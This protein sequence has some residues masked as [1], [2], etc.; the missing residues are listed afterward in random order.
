MKKT[1]GLFL[2]FAPEHSKSHGISRLLSFILTGIQK[3]QDT[4]IVI[5]TTEWFKHDTMAFLQNQRIDTHHIELLTTNK[6]ALLSRIIPIFL[7]KKSTALISMPQKKS[8]SAIKRHL[9]NFLM[10]H[11]LIQPVR[12]PLAEKWRRLHKKISTM[13]ILPD[14]LRIARLYHLFARAIY[15]A[16]RHRELNK[17]I[18]LINAR[19]DISIWFVPTLFWPEIKNIQAKKIIAVP[20]I[21]AVDFPEFFS[22]PSALKTVQ[23]MTESVKSGDH[24]ICYS[25]HVKQKHLAEA[26]SIEPD[27]ISVIPH[28]PVELSMSRIDAIQILH[29]YQ[30]T[31]LNNDPYLADYH[32]DDIRFIFYSSQVRPYKNFYHLIRA[33]EILLRE[34]FVNVK[35]ILT[36]DIQSDPA[37]YQMILDKRLQF[38]VLSFHD[39]SK[40]VLAALNHLAIC[41]VNP[42]LFEGGFPFT[43]TEAFSVGTPSVMSAIPAVT[44]DIKNEYLR[45]VMLFDP[46][47]IDDMVNK[48]E[49]AVNNRAKLVELQKPLYESFKQRDWTSVAKEYTDL[50]N[51]LANPLYVNA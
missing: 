32:L 11:R 20:D 43:F 47:N 5:A 8:A 41:A 17:L 14:R 15:H 42:T 30:K 2:A 3:D 26:F 12:K 49:W 21:V 31:V 34:R 19:P 29:D 35:L 45:K 44:A 48:I 28:A 6:N 18:R 46:H 9:V 39:V 4:Q 7:R 10:H 16:L 25:E 38:D 23:H 1:I 40:D 22:D 37:L 33:Y 24:F 36:G 27:R 50:F 51:Q 13:S